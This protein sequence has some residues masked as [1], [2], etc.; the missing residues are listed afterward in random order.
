MKK[1][2][3]VLI[4]PL[5]NWNDGGEE[6]R[7]TGKEFSYFR[8]GIEIALADGLRLMVRVLIVPLWNWNDKGGDP[9]EFKQMSSNCTFMEF[10][11]RAA[12]AY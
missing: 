8:F 2:H 9:E 4:V 1:N 10:T 3:K 12:N 5:W 6:R 7:G 11:L